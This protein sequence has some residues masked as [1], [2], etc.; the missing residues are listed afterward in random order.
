MLKKWW[1]F[2]LFIACFSF[3]SSNT[4]ATDST[5]GVD[6]VSYKLK[7][8]P[9]LA[10]KQ[11]DGQLEI[12]FIPSKAGLSEIKL[13][14]P[15]QTIYKVE[16]E[17]LAGYS[18]NNGVLILMFYPDALQQGRSTNVD[19]SYVANPRRGVTFDD[20][21]LFT[22]YHTA[23]WLLSHSDIGDKATIE[24]WLT[25]PEH[26]KAVA[27][28]DLHNTK[29]QNGN[30]T[31][32]YKQ[33]RPRPIFTFGFAAGNF[34]QTT[35]VK[36]GLTF[37]FL[38][39]NATESQIKTMFADVGAMGEFYHQISGKSFKHKAYTFVV[40]ETD[41]MQEASGFSLVGR[42]FI[43]DAL[44]DKRES[45]LAAHEL[46]HEWW[47][48]GVGA[49]SWQ[50]FWLSEGLVHY[51]VAEFKGRQYGQNEYAREI[52]MFKESF[53]AHQAKHG[54]LEAVSP[55]QS[56]SHEEFVSKH[57]SVVYS[58]GAFV[59]HMLKQHLGESVFWQGLQLY[60]K[61]HWESVASSKDLQR[62][63]EY[64]AGR[65]LNDFFNT[66]IYQ[67]Q[68]LQLT[69]EVGFI[70]GQLV[71][72]F[73][74][75]QDNVVTLNWKMAYQGN[76]GEEIKTVQISMDKV[77]HEVSLPMLHPP[78]ALWLDGM[79]F[80]PVD[81]KVKG[82]APYAKDSILMADNALNRYWALQSWLNITDCK[83]DNE[84]VGRI[85]KRL[86]VDSHRLIHKAYAQWQSDCS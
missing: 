7:I 11:L 71:M 21:H 69:A 77:E 10:K 38:Y 5:T 83:S 4:D 86:T 64:V 39:L 29:I 42:K 85:L 80:L 52:S 70:N 65:S 79:Q 67:P 40:T 74:Q 55:Y 47:G 8:T 24:T 76:V 19:I 23:E 1:F 13:L 51:I 56:I 81:I 54:Y 46:A 25:V 84:D 59:F 16:S 44:D 34:K 68:D 17:G 28:G 45:W 37:R 78:K 2:I 62:A 75:T 35:M 53:M 33:M 22:Q 63:F 27:A 26:Y 9:D 6:F 32:H 15:N 66:W 43:D 58:K 31:F 36:N 12:S 57:R 73:K 49:K 60:S 14:A 41:A 20:E 48:N 18:Q 82:L 3:F 50:D 72:R 61:R 30:K